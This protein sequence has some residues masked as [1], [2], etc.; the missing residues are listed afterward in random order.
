MTIQKTTLTSYS[1]SQYPAVIC[2]IVLRKT[3]YPVVARGKLTS[4]KSDTM[5]DHRRQ[6]GAREVQRSLSAN[7]MIIN[8]I[9]VIFLLHHIF[10][11]NLDHP[12]VATYCAV[13]PPQYHIELF[14]VLNN[15]M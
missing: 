6:L 11:L 15:K 7:D 12:C 13:R 1:V 2:L 9:S 10:I 3:Y 8:Y 5:A 14:S 4:V